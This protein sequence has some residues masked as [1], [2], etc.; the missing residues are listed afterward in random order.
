MS[1]WG[2]EEAKVLFEKL[3]FYN[4]FIEKPRVKHVLVQLEASK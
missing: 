2:D 3:S 4:T 1:F